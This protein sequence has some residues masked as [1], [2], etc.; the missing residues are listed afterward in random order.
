MDDSSQYSQIQM[1]EELVEQAESK[2]Q[3]V[4]ST[5]FNKVSCVLLP[6][7][8]LLDN[9]LLFLRTLRYRYFN[10]QPSKIVTRSWNMLMTAVRL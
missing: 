10:S 8:L 3:E 1:A 7:R 4:Y 9:Y 6:F 5:L 2:L